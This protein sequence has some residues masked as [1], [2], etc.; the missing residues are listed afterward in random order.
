MDEAFREKDKVMRLLLGSG[1]FSTDL[2]RE[3]W[4][5]VLDDFLGPVSKVLFI[6]FALKDHDHYVEKMIEYDFSAGRELVGIHRSS[7]FKSAIED[8]QAIYVGGGNSFRLLDSLQKFD[9]IKVIQKK[10][11]SGTPYIGVSAGTNMACPTLMTTNDMPIVYPKSFDSLNLI[12]FQIN[13]HYFAGATH[14][15]DCDQF[16]RYGGETRDD[17]IKEY[18]EMN[19]LPVLGLWEGAI[20][21]VEENEKSFYGKGVGVGSQ[22]EVARLFQK[23]K[24]TQVIYLGESFPEE[25]K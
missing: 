14:I 24:E 9:L 6:P 4:K 17:R 11:Q 22:P 3:G 18:H 23:D 8:A 10:V 1:G 25:L 13:P 7:D 21:R 15:E 19:N 5:E 16:I 2:R 20:L 12:S